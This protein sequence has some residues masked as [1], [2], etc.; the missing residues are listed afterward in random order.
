VSPVV[1]S[2]LQW[3]DTAAPADA[4]YTVRAL[5]R[6]GNESKPSPAVRVPTP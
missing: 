6:S 5:D 1:A 2:G 3:T 4:W